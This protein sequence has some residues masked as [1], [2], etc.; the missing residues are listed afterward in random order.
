MGMVEGL[1]LHYRGKEHLV[2]RRG[3]ALPHECGFTGADVA[4]HLFQWNASVSA[5]QHAYVIK[6]IADQLPND[7]KRDIGVP[8]NI[9]ESISA[10]DEMYDR[11][12]FMR[13]IEVAPDAPLSTVTRHMLYFSI[14][15]YYSVHPFERSHSKWRQYAAFLGQIKGVTFAEPALPKTKE[16]EVDDQR[17]I[18]HVPIGT[19]EDLALLVERAG[20]FVTVA[21]DGDGFVNVFT[22]LPP[23]TEPEARGFHFVERPEP[24]ALVTRLHE[25]EEEGRMARL[26]VGE[27]GQ[28]RLYAKAKKPELVGV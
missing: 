2:W 28:T 10:P 15:P 8:I 7:E 9:L 25:L 27:H 3:L 18:G 16:V 6:H 1:S 12:R 14:D 19:E 13:S 11:N 21:Q 23:Y 26:A 4:Y 22:Q 20:G 24:Q 17:L 5:A